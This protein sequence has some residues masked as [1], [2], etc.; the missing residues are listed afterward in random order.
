MV[1]WGGQLPQ[2]RYCSVGG[3]NLLGG[4]LATEHLLRLGGRRFAFLGDAALP[5]V[6]LRRDG[7][8]RALKATGVEPDDALELPVPFEVIAARFDVA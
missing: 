6:K 4:R 8:L 7:Y 2:Q 3:D 5:E 1:L